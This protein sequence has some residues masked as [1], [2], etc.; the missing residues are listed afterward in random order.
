MADLVVGTHALSGADSIHKEWRAVSGFLGISQLH[1]F[2]ERV[3][4]DE[5]VQEEVVP[6]KEGRYEIGHDVMSCHCRPRACSSFDL[7]VFQSFSISL[8]D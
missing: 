2:Q 8:L 4:V 5:G 3:S 7:Y 6:G 1:I